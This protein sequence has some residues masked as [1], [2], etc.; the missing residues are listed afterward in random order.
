MNFIISPGQDTLMFDKQMTRFV[1][2]YA[3]VYAY[4][5]TMMSKI[6]NKLGFKVRKSSFC[7]SKIKE[8]RI[9]L[10]VKG[11]KPIYQNMNKNFYKKNKLIHK[12][13]K[14][15]YKTNFKLTGFDKDPIQTL[16]IEAKKVNYVNKIKANKIFNNSKLNFNKYSRSILYDKT[17]NKKI[18]KY[19]IQVTEDLLY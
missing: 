4:D 11:L 9:P 18:K 2:G 5:F 19:K 14:G 16:F 1:G 6:L 12:Q 17:I 10:H 15:G 13:I 7:K 8:L 3:H